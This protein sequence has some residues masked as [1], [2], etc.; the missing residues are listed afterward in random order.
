MQPGWQQ[1]I[2]QALNKPYH[3]ETFAKGSSNTL[4]RGRFEDDYIVLRENGVAGNTPSVSRDRE[5]L[6]LSLI[7]SYRWAPDIIDNRVE[8]GWCVMR[9][10]SPLSDASPS[11]IQRLHLTDDSDKSNQTSTPQSI[12]K[13]A[14]KQTTPPLTEQQQIQLINAIS[15]LQDI[16]L[17]KHTQNNEHS[18]LKINYQQLWNTIYLPQALARNDQ[19]SIDWIKAI[20]QHFETLPLIPASLVHHDLHIGNLAL[21]IKSSIQEQD[22]LILLDWEYG[23]IGN[24]WLDAAALVNFFNIASEI[25]STL[26][27][28]RQLP[29]SVFQKGIAQAIELSGLINKLWYRARDDI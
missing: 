25:I 16:F 6:L 20:N 24:A 1:Y 18:T 28:F 4:Y 27:V 22:E 29:N 8:E 14:Q 5:A 3:W 17:K 15:D 12:N 23:G 9:C 11:E 7:S 2:N 13:P 19:Q 10:Y 21:D 26:P